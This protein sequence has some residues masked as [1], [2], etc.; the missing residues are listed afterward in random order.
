M[1]TTV[2]QGT[3][4]RLKKIHVYVTE[5]AYSLLRREAAQDESGRFSTGRVISTL[6]V[7]HLRLPDSR[8]RT[9]Y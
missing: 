2:A 4:P 9:S 8:A 7:K 6:A 1:D 5:E 3:V